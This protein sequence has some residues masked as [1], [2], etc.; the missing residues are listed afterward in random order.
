M[1]RTWKTQFVSVIGAFA[2]MICLTIAATTPLANAAAFVPG[3]A[4]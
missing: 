4:A 2:A 3:L 1:N